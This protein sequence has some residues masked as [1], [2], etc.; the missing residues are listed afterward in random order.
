M[1]E[2]DNIHGVDGWTDKLQ[3]LLKEAEKAAQSTD[4]QVRLKVS[5]RLTDFI[6]N[7]GPNVDEIMALDRVAE[8]ARAGL[9]RTTI[10]ERI[11][12]ISARTGELAR[13]TKEFKARA[14]AADASAASFRLEKSKKAIDSLTSTIQSLKELEAS[15]EDGN[16]VKVVDQVTKAVETIQKLRND[17]EAVL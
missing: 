4:L 15:F 12:S 9:L 8:K 6:L 7:S 5:S 1:S 10:E 14:E 3:E 13:L 11:I 17:V 16:N 2:L